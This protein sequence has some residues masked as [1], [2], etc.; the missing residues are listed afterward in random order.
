LATATKSRILDEPILVG[1]ERELEELQVSLNSAVDAEGGTIFVSGEA[2]SGKTRLINT[3]LEKARKQG[4]TALTGWCLNN[5]AVPYFPFFEAFNF[6]FSE[7]QGNEN[8]CYSDN[9]D[10]TSWLMGPSQGRQLENSPA[11]SP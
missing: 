11:I 6:C 2:G 8:V 1:R 4:I 9:K 7:T 3:F 5:T 10:I